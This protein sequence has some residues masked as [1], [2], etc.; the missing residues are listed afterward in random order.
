M[1]LQNVRRKSVRRKSVRRKSVRRKSV[2]RK[3]V[4]R[5]NTRR[6]G[7]RRKNTRRGGGRESTV[8]CCYISASQCNK[9]TKALSAPNGCK[10]FPEAPYSP[11]CSGRCHPKGWIPPRVK[12]TVVV[13]EST[14]DAA[15]RRELE[16]RRGLGR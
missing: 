7:S 4:R 3:S 9:I 12:S 2:R 8:E 15:A 14:A 16:A 1:A 5:K 11:A 10:V 13:P 6:G